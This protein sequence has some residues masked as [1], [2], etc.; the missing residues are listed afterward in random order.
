MFSRTATFDVRQ[1]NILKEGKKER[2]KVFTLSCSKGNIVVRAENIEQ[3][4]PTFLLNASFN[5]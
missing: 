1:E 4:F 5:V 2:F 3:F